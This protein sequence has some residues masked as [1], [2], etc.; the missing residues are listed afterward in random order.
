MEA[1]LI[2]LRIVSNANRSKGEKRPAD[3]NARAPEVALRSL[4]LPL[5][6]VEVNGTQNVFG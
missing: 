2:S 1:T 4:R 5:A 3:V 6:G